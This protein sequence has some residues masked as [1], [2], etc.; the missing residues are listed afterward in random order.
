V[1]WYGNFIESGIARVYFLTEPNPI[2]AS[3]LCSS[4]CSGKSKYDSTKSSTYKKDGRAW[5]I[6][7]GDGSTS[8]GV[9]GIDNVNL[10]GFTIKQQTIELSK[11]I[12]SSFTSDPIDGLLGLAF[13]SITSVTGVKT[14]MDNLISQKP[15]L[16]L[17][18]TWA[19]HPTVVV[20]NTSLVATIAPNSRDPLRLFLSITRKVSGES[21]CRP[22]LSME[23]LL[24]ARSLPSSTLEP[25]FF[26]SPTLSLP[27]LL[28]YTEPLTM[29]MVLMPLLATPP[30]SLLFHSRSM[31]PPSR[32]LPRISSLRTTMALALLALAM[33][34][35]PSPSW[36]TFSSRTI[37]SFSS[38]P[39][40]LASKLLLLHKFPLLHQSN[41]FD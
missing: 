29:E 23:S 37:M 18:S 4:T 10:G 3:T 17:V 28:L 14:P 40:P 24:Q 34:T 35:C 1:V 27:R 22:P 7:Y 8:S 41:Q 26:F 21:L 25:P 33:V 11:K 13:D 16:S 15:S 5:S 12:S 38:K 31:A 32:S 9:L 39:L 6:S 36:E 2:V 19:R 30:S 20:V